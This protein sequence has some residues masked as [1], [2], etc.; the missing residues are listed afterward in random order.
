VPNHVLISQ[1]VVPPEG[2]LQQVRDL[3]SQHNILMI[4]DEIQTG[5][6]RTGRMLA[7]DWENVRPDMVVS[8]FP[9]SGS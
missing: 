1:V 2:Y 8:G 4:A 5:I 9:A 7:V 6:A 3:C